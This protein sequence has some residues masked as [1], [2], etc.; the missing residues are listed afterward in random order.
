M[1]DV[2]WLALSLP[3]LVARLAP[4]FHRD[5]IVTIVPA[6]DSTTT[7]AKNSA[8]IA[9][10]RG[11]VRPGSLSVFIRYAAL[12]MVWDWTFVSFSVLISYSLMV[13][14]S[15]VLKFVNHESWSLLGGFCCNLLLVSS[16]RLR[17]LFRQVLD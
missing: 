15:T 10:S 7:F 14:S 2:N 13:S 12:C 11:L 3:L 9:W 17:I 6:Q 16:K 1:G 4:D 8:G 5:Q